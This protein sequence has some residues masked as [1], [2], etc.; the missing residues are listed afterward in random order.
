MTKRAV[1]YLR[2][3]KDATG[4]G[5]AVDR[6]RDLATTLAKE[7]GYTLS[8][9]DEYVDNSVSASKI[10]VV[11]PDYQRLKAD[12]EA[13]KIDAIFCYDLDR[14]T[15]QPRELEDWIDAAERRGLAIITLNGEADLTTD[16][17]RMYA[18][19]KVTVAKAE[20]DRKSRRQKDANAQRAAR[21]GVPKGER[22]T[23]YDKAGNVIEDEAVVVARIFSEFNRGRALTHI[24][25]SLTEDEVPSRRGGPWTPSSVRTVLLNPRYAG[26]RMHLGEVVA[27][28]DV[29][30]WTPIV[31]EAIYDRAQGIL[32]DPKRKT[33][34][35][36]TAR[37]YLGSGLFQC[38]QCRVPVRTNGQRY[39]CPQCGRVRTM[40]PIDEVVVS[41]IVDRL[42][43]P[44]M[45]AAMATPLDEAEDAR[46]A[47]VI[48]DARAHLSN[49]END[50]DE[51]NIDG[52]RYAAAHE[53]TSAKLQAALEARAALAGGD[54]LGR[55]ATAPDPGQAF[56]DADLDL[57][58]SIVDACMWV[59][60]K[61]GRQGARGFDP[62]DVVC[63]W[64]RTHVGETIS[65]VVPTT[66]VESLV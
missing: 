64:R 42:R 5:A 46:L 22:L 31:T 48:A 6:Q 56:L 44:D 8:K 17:G 15:R 25:Q 55:L 21:G 54:A 34:R 53:R 30:K 36:G 61:P 49:I 18:R 63:A 32:S 52:K 38:I 33:N 28:P 9:H 4:D 60:I 62:T 19:I 14:L 65:P 2:I 40:G 1:L 45:L 12:Y 13:G 50:Y 29:A 26:R 7:R 57:R 39:A 16:G 20:M 11:R 3:S 58:R 41:S 59:L 51:G 43:K 24:A 23:G 10:N 47:D 66:V 35:E 37:K 27:G